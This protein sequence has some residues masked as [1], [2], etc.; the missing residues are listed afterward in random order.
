MWHFGGSWEKFDGAEGARGLGFWHVQLVAAIVL[1][2]WANVPAG[3]SVGRPSAAMIRGFMAD[4][5]GA[6]GSQ[7]RCVE[8][9]LSKDLGV[10]RK[11]RI[12]SGWT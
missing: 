11:F 6:G 5:E 4:G 12:N 9:E 2:R 8:I 3:F 7:G 1:G 10:S